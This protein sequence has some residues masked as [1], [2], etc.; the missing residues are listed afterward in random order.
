MKKVT[1]SQVTRHL[2]KVTV[3]SNIC[4]IFTL[5]WARGKWGSNL[6]IS[7]I[8]QMGLVGKKN[9][10]Q[11]FYLTNFSTRNTGIQ[12]PHF[13][14]EMHLQSGSI[15]QPALLVYRSVFDKFLNKVDLDLEIINAGLKSPLDSNMLGKMFSGQISSRP[16]TQPKI[17]KIGV[18]L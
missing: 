18:F 9:T 14:K 8:F 5:I 11:I 17:S 1:R 2:F 13:W 4:G 10:K 15:F 6:T 16:K 7:Y 3:V 12:S